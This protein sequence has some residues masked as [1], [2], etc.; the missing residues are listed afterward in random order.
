MAV[1][2]AVRLMKESGADAVK[3]QG[4]REK[5]DSIKAVTV[6]GVPVMSHVG[7]LPHY[8]HRFGGFKLQGR[9]A[10]AAIE[11]VDNAR[12]I[13]EAGA[14]WLEIEAMPYEVGKAGDEAVDIVTFYI[15]AGSAGTCQFL[16]GYDPLGAFDRFKPKFAKH[17]ANLAEIAVRA[18]ADYAEDMRSGA[19]PDAEHSYQMKPEELALFQDIPRG[20][21]NERSCKRPDQR[22]ATDPER[23]AGGQLSPQHVV[24]YRPHRRSEHETHGTMAAGKNYRDVSSDGWNSVALDNRCPHRC[25]L[26]PR[27]AWSTTSWSALVT[28]WPLALTAAVPR[29]RPRPASRNP[30]GSKAIPCAS[31]VPFCGFGWA[32]PRP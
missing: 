5:F 19:L 8:V 10:E 31:P 30:R 23:H 24:V 18:F 3:L 32:N 26:C 1:Q 17:Y 27:A 14:I 22:W 6:A 12:A 13:Q 21:A 15:G 11:I 20:K 9:T 16:N 29:F 2:N 25:P 4:G 28:A 7:L